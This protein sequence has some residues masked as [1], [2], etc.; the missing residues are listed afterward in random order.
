VSQGLVLV[1]AGVVMV[2]GTFWTPMQLQRVEAKL[3]E[4]GGDVGRFR[5]ARNG[6]ILGTLPR[7]MGALG[8]VLVVWGVVS[9]A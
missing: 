2:L 8:A 6:F 9:L 7:L 3:A 1:V 5:D 4:R